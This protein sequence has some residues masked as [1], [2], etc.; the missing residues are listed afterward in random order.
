M[1]IPDNKCI[2][3]FNALPMNTVLSITLVAT[4][5]VVVGLIIATDCDNWAVGKKADAKT[6]A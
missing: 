2:F 1:T 5:Q 6:F 4:L 3:A